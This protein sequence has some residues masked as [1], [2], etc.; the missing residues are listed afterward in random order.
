MLCPKV[1][2]YHKAQIIPVLKASC[3][4]ERQISKIIFDREKF[5]QSMNVG[6]ASLST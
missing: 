2:E 3:Y 1:E 6:E 5:C 4:R